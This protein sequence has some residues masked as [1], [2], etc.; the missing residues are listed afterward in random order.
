[1]TPTP[2]DKQIPSGRMEMRCERAASCESATHPDAR[3]DSFEQGA[4]AQAS[5]TPARRLGTS[6]DSAVRPG[7][8]LGQERE[9]ERE[10]HQR[11]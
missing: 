4:Y 3:D 6:G 11:C 8:L 2:S 10:M 9:R 7:A 1:M 5:P